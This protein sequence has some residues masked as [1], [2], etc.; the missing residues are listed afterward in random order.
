METTTIYIVQAWDERYGFWGN[1]AERPEGM[2]AT[3]KVGYDTEA[4]GRGRLAARQ[5]ANPDGKYRLVRQ[6]TTVEVI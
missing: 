5:G 2:F 6:V 4:E 1:T 3:P